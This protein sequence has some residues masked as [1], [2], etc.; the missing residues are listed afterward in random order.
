MDI[1]LHHSNRLL[2][3]FSFKEDGTMTERCD[4]IVQMFSCFVLTI[5]PLR[6]RKDKISSLTSLYI[7]LLN[8]KLAKEISGFE[9]DAMEL[10]QNF[11][12]PGNYNQ[13]KRILT[14][15]VTLTDTPHIKTETVSN[16]LL[17]EQPTL[18]PSNH[19]ETLDL[20]R[21]LDEINLDIILRV[22]AEENNHQVATAKRLGISRSTLWRILQKKKDEK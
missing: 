6:T 17:Q 9:N 15:L 21:T 13:F 19:S 14:E 12:W 1:N 20:N 8:M 10:L 4:K 7:N 11:D 3:S 5:P 22:L 2:F 18:F 16:L